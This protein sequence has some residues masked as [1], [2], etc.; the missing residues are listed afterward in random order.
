[1]IKKT[2]IK[3]SVW[4]GCFGARIRAAIPDLFGAIKAFFL[5]SVVFVVPA[6][7][8]QPIIKQHIEPRGSAQGWKFRVLT[9]MALICWALLQ[10]H[11]G[12]ALVAK[13][14]GTSDTDCWLMNIK[15]GGVTRF[16]S[17]AL[18]MS[19]SR[20]SNTEMS[21]GHRET[22]FFLIPSSPF[23]TLLHSQF[24]LV[25]KKKKSSSGT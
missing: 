5:T 15:R 14:D 25:K 16:L 1:M 4:R 12:G 13:G 24:A 17:L 18:E 7:L 20:F 21:C 8:S 22:P 10:R 9:Q 23:H 11:K 6:R 3:L 2:T 19:W